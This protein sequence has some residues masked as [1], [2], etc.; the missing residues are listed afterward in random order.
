MFRTNCMEDTKPIMACCCV[1]VSMLLSLVRVYRHLVLDRFQVILA[2][3]GICGCASIV[4][5]VFLEFLLISC[6][7]GRDAGLIQWLGYWDDICVCYVWL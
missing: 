5:Y 4:A 1:F 7:W 2:A 3:S 6:L